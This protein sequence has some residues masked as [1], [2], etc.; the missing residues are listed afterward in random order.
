MSVAILGVYVGVIIDEVF[1]A[2]V[3]RWIYVDN[4]DFALVCVCESC[5]GFE[6][7]PLNNYMVWITR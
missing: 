3:V 7:I 2:G 4:I 5:Q 6:V 1:V